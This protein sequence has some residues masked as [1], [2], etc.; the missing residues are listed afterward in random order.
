MVKH[1][2]D[3]FP[4]S[5]SSLL[6]LSTAIAIGVSRL[7]FG[8]L[9][10]VRCL[11]PVHMQ[12][13]ALLTLGITTICIPTAHSFAGL[14]VI[15]IVVGACDGL[16][17]FLNGPI[18]FS[19]VGERDASQALGFFL[20]TIS[21]P[22]TVGPPLAGLLYDHLGSYTVA[23][24]V[25]GITPIAGALIMLLIPRQTQENAAANDE[26]SQ[27]LRK[28]NCATSSKLLEIAKMEDSQEGSVQKDRVADNVG[29]GG[30][31]VQ[32]QTDAWVGSVATG[33]TFLISAVAGVASD[34]FG[35]RKVGFAGGFLAFIGMLSSA[36]VPDLM[37]LYLTYGVCIG[38]GS[39]FPFTLAVVIL[40]HYF[41]KK[42]GF[43]NA[44]ATLGS[45]MFSLLYSLM[46]PALIESVGLK[47]TFVCLSGVHFLL[48]PCAMTWKSRIPKR[49]KISTGVRES[50]DTDGSDDNCPGLCKC[51]NVRIW[52]NRGYVAWAAGTSVAYFGSMVPYFHLVK[53]SSDLFPESDAN[54]LPLSSAVAI[55]VARLLFA[56]VADV[57]CLNPVHMQQAA[58]L[59]L[60]I[61]TICIPTAHSFAGLVVISIVVGACDG[62][63]FFLNGPIV[64]RL[65]GERDA[66]Q[67]LGFF[68]STISVPITVGAPL[69]GLL[70]DHLGSYTVAFGVAGIAPIAG[71]LIMFLI[72]DRPQV[73]HEL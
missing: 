36:F 73:A 68:L 18:V 4:E 31:R 20:S 54:L 19:L 39:A 37:L 28:T 63:F 40:G 8:L 61:T 29:L 33:L 13:A 62:L 66:S 58:L 43:V 25:A 42:L 72:P 38:V 67:A 6:P 45:C 56:L 46:I 55:G 15:S 14:V 44:I 22:I 24:H 57:H 5:N 69:A 30:G 47:Y 35:L 32:V 9:T 64:F 65:V 50:P 70:Y 10:D 1:S 21:V 71:A 23:F 16:F 51:C 12:Q 27:S 48:M 7:G 60:G 34:R 49:R 53:H 11:N 59:T 41:K 2:D 26:A 3:L 17:F 52:R